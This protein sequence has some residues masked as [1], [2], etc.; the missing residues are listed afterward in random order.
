MS[1]FKNISQLANSPVVGVITTALKPTPVGIA[2]LASK[3]IT[4]KSIPQHFKNSIKGPA[5]GTS[6]KVGPNKKGD[7]TIE[8]SIYRDAEQKNI[9][10]GRKSKGGLV[11]YKNIQDMD[12]GNHS[13]R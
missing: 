10:R 3:V 1:K 7:S 4:G 5:K 2:N 11:A 6:N 9:L 12:N 8:G 13:K